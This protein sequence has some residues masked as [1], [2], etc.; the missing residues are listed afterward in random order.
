VEIVQGLAPGEHVILH[1][2]DRIAAGVSVTGS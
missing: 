2:T 1:P